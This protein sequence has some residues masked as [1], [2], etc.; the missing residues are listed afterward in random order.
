MV[1][2]PLPL[3]KPWGGVIN[4]EMIPHRSHPTFLAN[5]KHT[6]FQNKVNSVS[7][8]SFSLIEKSY[9]YDFI[10]G[11]GMPLE[12]SSFFFLGFW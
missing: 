7:F 9:H 6:V 10:P 12:D 1:V 8:N 2:E 11:A 3:A 5:K 4:K